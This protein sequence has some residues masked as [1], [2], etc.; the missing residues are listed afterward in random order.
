MT[1]YMHM[2]AGPEMNALVA[3]AM[4]CVRCRSLDPRRSD[5]PPAYMAHPGGRVQVWFGVGLE[6][7][8]AFDW[9]PST[10]DAAAMEVL[11]K[12]ADAVGLV[13]ILFMPAKFAADGKDHWSVGWST[14]EGDEH[15]ACA[16]TLP[17]ASCRAAL[18]VQET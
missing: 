9:R 11:R 6:G 18:M 13:E 3:E 1:D 14:P 2:E 16:D 5:A 8:C 12:L 17:L 15:L 7:A 10:D 4:G